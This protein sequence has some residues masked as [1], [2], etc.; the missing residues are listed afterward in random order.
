MQTCIPIWGR[1]SGRMGTTRSWMWTGPSS[2]WNSSKIR[3]QRC[4]CSFIRGKLALFE[5]VRVCAFLKINNLQCNAD[6]IKN[7]CDGS[8]RTASSQPF[9]RQ[10]YMYRHTR[11][12]AILSWFIHSSPSCE[13]LTFLCEK[14]NASEL[15]YHTGFE[16][17]F[18]NFTELS[19]NE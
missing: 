7:E 4:L 5:R 19:Y 8:V 18:S 2:P 3:T 10:T 17:R 11:V 1:E 13:P 16:G 15:K 9:L 14:I 12:R 6:E